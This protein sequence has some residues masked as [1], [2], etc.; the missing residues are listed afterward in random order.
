MRES[1]RLLST[2]PIR[3][4]F[5]L[6]F[7]A[8]EEAADRVETEPSFPDHGALQLRAEIDAWDSASDEA[9]EGM[10]EQLTER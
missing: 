9:L 2:T 8:E 3:P 10:D 7:E 5:N 1:P 4:D 6:S